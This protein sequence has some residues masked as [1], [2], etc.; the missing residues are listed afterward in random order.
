MFDP[1]LSSMSITCNTESDT[2]EIFGL[3][4]QLAVDPAS[5]FFGDYNGY[6]QEE[7][8]MDI[9]GEIA[10]ALDDDDGHGG[11]KDRSADGEKE[12]E[13]LDDEIALDAFLAEQE[14]SL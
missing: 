13:E 12:T 7:W 6:S 1:A 8:G 5:D 14:Q 9:D 4:D 3:N 11:E 2:P 10:E